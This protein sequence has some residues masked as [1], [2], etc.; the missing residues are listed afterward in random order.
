MTN[1]ANSICVLDSFKQLETYIPADLILK[2]A[3]SDYHQNNHSLFKLARLMKGYEH[4]IGRVVTAQE[5]K[6]VFDRWCSVAEL[7]WRPKLTRDD[8]W[9]EF[10]EAYH[11]ARIGLDEDPLEVALS[12]ART[13][14]LPEV[15]GFRDERVKL[16]AGICRE[17]QQLVGD[18]S[19]FLPTRKL[20]KLLGASWP[21][22]ARWLIALDAL[23]II[24]LAPG[25]VRKQGGNRSPRYHCSTCVLN[26]QA[27]PANR[28]LTSSQPDFL[29]TV[30]HFNKLENANHDD[31]QTN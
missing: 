29:P 27:V 13:M 23:D 9:A 1:Q 6:F 16:L 22:V 20:G 21:T 30:N 12:R 31:S 19:F 26:T 7:F 18:K 24:R 11:Y 4:A 3:P 8:Y 14:P 5:L 17:M 15:V 25:E 2:I 28:P 10:L